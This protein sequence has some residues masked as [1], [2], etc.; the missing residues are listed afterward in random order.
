MQGDCISI[1]QLNGDFSGSCD[2]ALLLIAK[3]EG[4][5]RFDHVVRKQL[6]VRG[7][8][9]CGARVQRRK[10]R[11]QSF[12]SMCKRHLIDYSSIST[13]VGLLN[14]SVNPSFGRF[15][16]LAFSNGWTDRSTRSCGLLLIYRWWVPYFVSVGCQCRSVNNNLELKNDMCKS[17]SVYTEWEREGGTNQ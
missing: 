1:R 5:A 2:F 3:S 15:S 10:S 12:Y 9:K 13:V 7:Y 16:R 17:S 8:V 11:D 6:D 14:V 4:A